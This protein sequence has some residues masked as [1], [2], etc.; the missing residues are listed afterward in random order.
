MMP[1]KECN[2]QHLV[3]IVIPIYK[4]DLNVYETV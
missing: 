4:T 2:S 3:K 1:N